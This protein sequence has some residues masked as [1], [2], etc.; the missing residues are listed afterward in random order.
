[1]QHW[2]AV[3]PPGNIEYRYY[4]LCTYRYPCYSVFETMSIMKLFSCH[5]DSDHYHYLHQVMSHQ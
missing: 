4:V 5:H 2:T 1:M 3:L